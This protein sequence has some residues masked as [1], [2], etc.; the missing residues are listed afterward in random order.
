MALLV[1]MQGTQK[2]ICL[3]IAVFQLCKCWWYKYK[4][5]ER[6]NAFLKMCN[7]VGFSNFVYLPQI[8]H[9]NFSFWSFTYQNYFSI[10]WSLFSYRS[11][12]I[13]WYINKYS[14]LF[15][16]LPLI[17]SDLDVMLLQSLLKLLPMLIQELKEIFQDQAYIF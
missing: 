13:N 15:L 1:E 8:S 16:F 17:T 5:I 9:Y 11:E 12:K 6:T 7:I 2:Y 3:V 10:I 14:H 4:K